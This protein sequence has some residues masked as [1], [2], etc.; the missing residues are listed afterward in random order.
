MDVALRCCCPSRSLNS[1]SVRKEPGEK[2]KNKLVKIL[3]VIIQLRLD[4]FSRGPTTTTKSGLRPRVARSKRRRRSSLQ[5]DR[6]QK[7][8]KNVTIGACLPDQTDEKNSKNEKK[9]TWFWLLSLQRTSERYNNGR[10][11]QS[12]AQPVVQHKS[13]QTKLN[14]HNRFVFVIINFTFG[15]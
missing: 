10:Q 4:Q 11:Q 7:K 2:K 5:V 8:K 1:R 3:I 12:A 6:N 9:F 14:L 15:H 13:N